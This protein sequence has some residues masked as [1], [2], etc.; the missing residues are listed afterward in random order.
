MKDTV[1]LSVRKLVDMFGG[2][3]LQFIVFKLYVQSALSS[4]TSV[5][6]IS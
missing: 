1:T 2:G 3:G 5:D 6:L 4:F